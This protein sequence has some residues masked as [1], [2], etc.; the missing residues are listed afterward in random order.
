MQ[1]IIK[2]LKYKYLEDNLDILKL[3]GV[4]F[5]TKKFGFAILHWSLDA[6]LPLGVMQR[7]KKDIDLITKVLLTNKCN[8]VII[9]NCNNNSNLKHVVQLQHEIQNVLGVPVLLEDEALTT[10]A[11]NEMLRDIGMKRKNRDMVDDAI[12][13]QLILEGFMSDFKKYI[14]SNRNNN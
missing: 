3:L 10:Y 6:V 13:A 4:D 2:Q 8:G 12:A 1:K 11:A 14:Y 7:C 5:G 9:G